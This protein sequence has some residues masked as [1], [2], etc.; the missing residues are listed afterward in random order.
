MQLYTDNKKV[1]KY[2][3][4]ITAQSSMNISFMEDQDL[5][6]LMQRYHENLQSRGMQIPPITYIRKGK[7][8][9]E[10]LPYELYQ[11]MDH[12]AKQTRQNDMTTTIIPTQWNRIHLINN[13]G[14]I[15]SKEKH[16]LETNWSTYR[17]EQYYMDRWEIT[18]QTLQQ[19]DWE[20]YSTVYQQSNFTTKKFMIKVMTGWL[21]VYH[22][23]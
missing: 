21:P 19:Y 4:H 5:Y 15:T 18:A 2:Q 7:Q 9:Q 6:L 12:I 16:L 3:H 8:Q 14:A 17:I 20:N 11:Q 22:L 13:E 10:S 23:F 1:I